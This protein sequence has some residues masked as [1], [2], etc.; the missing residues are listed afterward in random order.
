MKLRRRLQLLW[1]NRKWVIQSIY[2]TKNFLRARE[3]LSLEKEMNEL[4]HEAKRGGVTIDIA[5]AKGRL[6]VVEWLKE[7]E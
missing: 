6:E 1:L 3:L 2:N 5:K 4:Y 7:I